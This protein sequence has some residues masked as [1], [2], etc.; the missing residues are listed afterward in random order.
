MIA[1][2][3]LG[4]GLS[5]LQV[6]RLLS[7][8]SI[9][10]RVFESRP[11]IGGLCR[12]LRSGDWSWDI[13]PHAF[14]SRHPEIMRNYESLPL[15]YERLKRRVR[16]CHHVPDGNVVEV[17]YPFENGIADL[18]WAQRWACLSGAISAR[19]TG[20]QPYQ[21]LAH[22]IEN[23]LGSGIGELFMLPYNRKIWNCPLDR[24]SM[25]L[26]KGKIEPEPLWRLL[27]NTLFSGTVGRAYQAEFIYPKK[28]AGSIPDAVY[29]EVK[30][31]V[32]VEW[33]L[34]KA[35]R[36]KDGWRLQS[37]TG[38]LVEARRV[39]STIPIPVLLRALNDP[40]LPSAEDFLQN[41]T[42]FT[43]VGL[44]AGRKFGT[45][46]SCQWTFFA[47]P[48]VFYRL[49]FMGSFSADG[50]P[51]VVAE[52]TKKT[53]SLTADALTERVLKDLSALG[54]LGSQEDVGMAQTHL[55]S[56]TYPIQSVGM[57]K[58]REKMEGALT[59]RGMHLL[60]RSGRWDYVNTDGVF[61]NAQRFVESFPLEP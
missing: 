3:I 37:T 56:C 6:A 18:P 19:L 47:G 8:R 57:E 21:N 27:R 28:R 44:K 25:A 7:A 34:A 49:T 9:D 58:I 38:E 22:W 30:D 42:Y 45:F 61:A 32:Q 20:E 23:G 26:V 16:V 4:G 13:G 24:I 39:I 5:G 55:E 17:G 52:T 60:G 10:C 35:C 11:V 46:G 29:N 40:S 41:D 59:E 33:T 48:E 15:E 54:V 43:A 36:S 2:A 53:D 1:V 12:T 31:R 51:V 14:Y 50:L